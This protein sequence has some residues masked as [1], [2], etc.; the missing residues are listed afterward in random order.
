VIRRESTLRTKSR[1]PKRRSSARAD[2]GEALRAVRDQL[3]A[4]AERGVFRGLA[5][6][7]SAR[8]TAAFTFVWL[9]D[10]EMELDVDLAKHML[11]FRRLLP[12]MSAGSAEYAAVKAFVR[13]RHGDELPE[14]RRIDP[15]RALARSSSRLGSVS[16]SLEV[17]GHDYVYGVQRFVNLVHELFVYLRDAWPEYLVEHFDAVQE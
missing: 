14:H 8:T 15:R 12:G 9:L 2:S 7:K 16:I 10:Q 11:R 3:Q 5:E 17:R 13:E 4:Y 1:Q 6:I